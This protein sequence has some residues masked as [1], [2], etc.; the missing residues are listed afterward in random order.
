[1]ETKQKMTIKD[2]LIL[3][4]RELMQVN[5]LP[6]NVLLTAGQ[7]V[8]MALRI[9]TDCLDSITQN[10]R[11]AAEKQQQ[12]G[13]E[14]GENTDSSEPEVVFEEVIEAQESAPAEPVD[15]KS[16]QSKKR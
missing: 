5:D 4:Y 6:P 16:K 1:M 9:T 8:G 13:H 15:I 2:A 14:N 12:E 11:E 3:I 7:H 10:E